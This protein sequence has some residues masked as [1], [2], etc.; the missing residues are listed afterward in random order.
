[1]L[2]ST[3]PPHL[4]AGERCSACG[5]P[6]NGD[7]YYLP[8]RPERYCAACM[9][10]RPRCDSCGAPAGPQHWRLHDGRVN[11]A[12][13]HATAV[14]DPA[15]AQQLFYQTVG[16]VVDDLN[17][18]LRVGVAFRLLDAPGLAQRRAAGG[19]S[20]PHQRT[21]GLYERHSS[22][23]RLISLLYGLPR[24]VFRS[25]AAHEYAHAWQGE[26]CPLL[27]DHDLR[28]GFAEWVAYRHLRYLGCAKAARELL[29]SQHPYRPLLERMLALEQQR[30]A[31][32]VIDHILAV[33]RGVAAA[34]RF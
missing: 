20:D 28:E 24:I 13:C 23:L 15:E 21:L 16:A 7:V 6:L 32:G 14:Y 11:C 1:M 17:L 19:A 27:E 34:S 8:G 29:E 31:A 18:S 3:R 33:G 30:G 9:V 12:R 5:Q 25:V 22:S 10:Q 26:T 4:A 2:T